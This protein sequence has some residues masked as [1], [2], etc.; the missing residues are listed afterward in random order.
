MAAPLGIVGLGLMGTALADRLAAA[1]HEVLGHDVDPRRGEDFARPTTS[2]LAELFSRCRVVFLSLPTAA[3]SAEVLGAAGASLDGVT[4]VDT[5]T[6]EPEIAAA[7]G[8]SVQA[9][10]GAYLDGTISGNSEQLR[11][12]DVLVMVGGPAA[13]FRD[14]EPLLAQLGRA[15]FRVGDWGAGMRMKLV[16]NL[17]LGLNRAALAEG[18]AFA[19]ALGLEPAEALRVLVASNAHSRV[20]DAKGDKMVRGDFAPQARLSQHRK[21]VRLILRASAAAGLRLPLTEAHD[22]L[23]AEAERAGL[24]EA[25]NSA[26]LRAYVT[27][28]IT[29]G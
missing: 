28:R 21:D 25:D 22:G 19:G 3:I 7:L 27:A 24:G 26:I 6:G 12:G 2:S 5:S 29:P 15:V 1:G 10:G 23:L 8:P 11:S 4:V 17:V 9:R 14:H 16:T 18:L 20:M 13:V